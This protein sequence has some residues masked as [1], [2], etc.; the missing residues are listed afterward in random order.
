NS[1]TISIARIT[2]S[3]IENNEAL[4]SFASA[5]GIKVDNNASLIVD[6][7]TIRGNSADRRGGG[8][9]GAA[10]SDYTITNSTISGNTASRG[11][12]VS[13]RGIE[14]S[15]TNSTIANNVAEIGGGVYIENTNKLNSFHSVTLAN[16]TATDQG[17]GLY[18]KSFG[19]TPTQIVF[20]NSII[21]DNQAANGGNDIFQDAP[22]PFDIQLDFSLI[23]DPTGAPIA[24]DGNLTGVAPQI[25]PLANNG[26]TTET[27]ALLPGSQA[28][29]AGDPAAAAGEGSVPEFDQRLDGFHRVVDGRIDMGA[30]ESQPIVSEIDG[31][32]DDDGDFDCDDVD[33]LVQNIADDTG[34]LQFDLDGN[35]R[36]DRDDLNAWLAEAGAANNASGG[37]YL[38]G[39][40]NLNGVVD[41]SDFNLW[42]ANKF[43]QTAAWCSADFNADGNVDIS[44]FNIWNANKFNSSD[45]AAPSTGTDGFAFESITEQ[46][47]SG[48]YRPLDEVFRTWHV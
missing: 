45:S 36:L 38:P 29:N 46:S 14:G 48:R 44:D 40:A 16:N 32:F 18:T 31:D 21:A 1:G 41:I 23:E 17:G 12:G 27:M 20:A 43:T 4:A 13:A 2:D 11:G 39:D 26:G 7:S 9:D 47:P 8:L 6:N 22:T 5:G 28:I 35:G 15:I 37:A 24:G 33:A 30:F 10:L 25:G 19:N 34:D 3:L 42:N